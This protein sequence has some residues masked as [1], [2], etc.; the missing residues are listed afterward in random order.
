MKTAEFF[1]LHP[2]FSLE[3]AAEALNPTGGQT[4]TIERLKYY[5]E[6]GRLKLITRG[7][8]A[9]IPSSVDPQRFQP[10]PFLTAAAVRTD[11][12]FSHHSALELLG[13]AHSMWGKITLYT[14]RRRKPL[15]LDGSS[16]LFLNHP[17]LKISSLPESF[18]TQR[19]ERRGQLLRTTGPERTLVEGFRRPVLAGG[20]EELVDSAIGFPTLSLDLLEQV[21]SRY[22]IA[23]LWAATGWFLERFRKTFQVNEEFLEKIELRCPRSPQYLERNSRGGWLASRW[24]L[25][26]PDALKQPAEYDKR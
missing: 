3:M 14:E 16:I 24:N 25:I 19:V 18:G 12:V 23:I 11:A 9:V 7:I 22:D 1:S 15:R 10:D 20:L 13:A 8:Y 17:R 26:L 2:V 6:K 5:L 4:G 21:L